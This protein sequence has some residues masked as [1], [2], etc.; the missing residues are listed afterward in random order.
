MGEK[1][2]KVTVVG[3]ILVLAGALIVLV[4]IQALVDGRNRDQKSEQ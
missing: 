3:A 2:M 1:A 4:L